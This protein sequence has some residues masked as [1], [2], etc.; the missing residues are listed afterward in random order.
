MAARHMQGAWW[1]DLRF[2]GERIRKKSPINTKKGA[3]E[4][5]RKLRADLGAPGGGKEDEK[6][7]EASTKIVPTLEA[8]SKEF[9]SVYAKANNKPS[10]VASKESILKH[11]LVPEVRP[12]AARSD[13]WPSHRALQG[14]GVG[15]EAQAE[16]DQQ[17][18]DGAVAHARSCCGVGHHS[19]RPEDEVAEGAG[20][21]V[22]F[23]HVRGSRPTGERA[24][25]SG[26]RVADDDLACA[27]D[28]TAARRVAR[29]AVGR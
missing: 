22:R 9:I 18:P 6:K 4:F 15:R 19:A 12:P 5:E 2:K 27:E 1:V 26:R 20:S 29:A 11:H 14:E 28:G 8:F 25:R 13:R 21:G 24:R 16:V 3:E 23:P 10:E 17:L 7:I